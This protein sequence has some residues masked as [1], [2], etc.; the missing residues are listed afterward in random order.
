VETVVGRLR[1][2]LAAQRV[3]R[4]R[5]EAWLGQLGADGRWPDVAY[6]V[7]KSRQKAYAPA[8]HQERCKALALLLARRES[9]APDLLARLTRAVAVN[10]TYQHDPRFTWSHD[11]FATHIAV[12]GQYAEVLLLLDGLLPRQELLP[13]AAHLRDGLQVPRGDGKPFQFKDA[14]QN[15]VWVARVSMA[16]AAVERDE[17]LMRQAFS[18]AFSTVA[19]QRAGEEGIKVD[20]MF[21]QH[22]RQLY[23][24]GY[25]LSYVSDMVACLRL[26]EGTAFAR[27]F[28]KEQIEIFRH[29]LLQG[30]RWTTCRDVM[31]FG[32]RGRTIARPRSEGAVREGDLAFLAEFDREASD[33]YRAWIGHRRGEPFPEPGNR[34]FWKSD[35]MAHRGP[36][37][38]CSVKV[39]SQRTAGTETMNGENLLGHN[40]PLGATCIMRTGREYADLY[41]A[42]DWSR[43]PGTT[44]PLGVERPAP[45]V[46]KGSN[47]FAGGASDGRSGVLA[48]QSE[49][50]GVRASK[51]YF[52]IGDGLVCLTAGVA[53]QDK[54]AAVATSLNQCL[55]NGPVWVDG[56]ELKDGRAGGALRAIHH[57]GVGYVLLDE[58]ARVEVRAASQSGSW[59]R[60]SSGLSSEP[61]AKEVFSAWVQHAQAAQA[62]GSRCAY[63]VVPGVDSKSVAGLAEAH[64]YE[65]VRNDD[66]AQAVL[67]RGRGVLGAVFYK[68][69]QLSAGRGVTVAAD[70]P[71]VVL[72]ARGDQTA[73]VWVGD[74]LCAAR[75]IRVAVAGLVFTATPGDGD[76]LGKCVAAVP[77]AAG[78]AA[79]RLFGR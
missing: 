61:L 11:W 34:H 36:D 8:V 54:Q 7:D 43:I 48:F 9:D 47:P 74:P 33:A 52:G 70:A 67:H 5:A 4:K 14:A 38:Y 23:N 42:W 59:K 55:L 51:A 37:W 53:W 24:G 3:D 22:G 66:V 76:A 19:Y 29:M 28:R 1:G 64:G 27:E 65:V 49:Y 63:L 69:G 45:H 16:K 26:S 73:R 41:P 30:H 77:G 58:G 21:H 10:L 62:D 60:I 13:L 71:A 25:G 18:A 46:F 75:R 32:S 39:L 50:G 31:D 57:D 72:V 44:A 15:L 17:A 78:D 2:G 79:G 40:L 20:G 56:Q 12:P 35:F 68:P 6:G